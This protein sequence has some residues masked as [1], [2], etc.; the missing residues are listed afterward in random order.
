MP[1]L[2]PLLQ[3]IELLSGL[4]R[5]MLD[6]L[7][8]RGSSRHCPPGR[9][10]V[11]EGAE[12]SGLQLITDG[13]AV[14]IVGDREVRTLQAGDYFGE[15]SLIDHAPRSATVRAS[16]DGCTTFSIS[17]LSFSQV[18]DANPAMARLLLLALTARIRELEA[19]LHG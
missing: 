9:D 5:E 3:K 4:S 16:A 8:A 10:L 7:V 17:P 1:A 18:M 6:E 12:D 11:T 2:V 13:T 14:V 19:R 15:M